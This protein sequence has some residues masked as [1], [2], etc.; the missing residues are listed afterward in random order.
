MSLANAEIER[1]DNELSRKTTHYKKITLCAGTKNCANE[2][3]DVETIVPAYESLLD[4]AVSLVSDS[5]DV[6]LSS[7]PPRVDDVQAQVL[8]DE[9]NQILPEIASAKSVSFTDHAKDF[10]CKRCP[11]TV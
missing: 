4:T 6:T 8:V 7:I 11:L 3:A 10:I 5:K 9:I 2:V 1:I